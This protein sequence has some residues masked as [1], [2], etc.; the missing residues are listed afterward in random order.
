MSEFTQLETR[1]D[2]PGLIPRQLQ[3]ENLESPL[4]TLF[5]WQTPTDLFYLRNHLP[6]PTIDMD[7]WNLQIDGE[8]AGSKSYSYDDL[9]NMPHV[10]K[11]VTIECSGNKRGLL[12]PPAL[13][14]QWNIGAIGNAKWTGVPLS[15]LLDQFEISALAREVVFK[16]CD[17]GSRPDM[18]GQFH[19]ERSLPLDSN[20]LDECIIA[21]WMND[22]PLPYKHGY[23]ARLIVPG[24]YGMAHVKWLNKLTFTQDKFRGP[25]QAI[26]Y[27]YIDNEDDF[28]KAVPV[29]EIKVN[30]IITWP[31]KGEVIKPGVHTIRG[32]A[33]AGK[34]RITEVE[35]SLDNGI[36]WSNARLTSPEHSSYTWTFWEYTWTVSF[37]GHYFLTVRAKDSFGDVQPKQARWNAKGYANNSHHRVEVTVPG[38]P[39]PSLQ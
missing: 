18:P 3:P 16:G 17:Y 22:E 36:S 39:A 13:G 33:W 20:L 37:P 21:L 28:S 12:E 9:Y 4:N 25:F 24:W 7:T 31:A 30:S 2:R 10:S 8:V 23:P 11:F 5:S 19:F 27:V 35:I 34:A 38:I 15:Y 29:T 32:I 1:L 26:D 6:Y 14:E